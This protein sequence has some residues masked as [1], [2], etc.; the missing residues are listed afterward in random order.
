[1][2][3][4]NTAILLLLSVF[5]I[6]TGNASF[7][8]FAKENP[9]LFAEIA[10]A[11]QQWRQLPATQAWEAANDDL[12]VCITVFKQDEC[13]E[14]YKKFCD[15]RTKTES[16]CEHKK[17]WETVTKVGDLFKEHVEK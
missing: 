14:L 10:A 13:D 3:K 6:A 17:Y 9:A 4:K 7:E 8:Q 12:H 1:M 2:N 16:T 15:L 5:S 11:R